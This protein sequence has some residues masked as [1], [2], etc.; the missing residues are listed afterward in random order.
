MNTFFGQDFLKAKFF[1]PAYLH[2]AGEAPPTQDG[3]SG[4]WRLF[5]MKMQEEALKKN[6]KETESKPVPAEVVA[7]K[8]KRVKRR[9]AK[10]Q[11]EELPAPEIKLAPFVLRPVVEQPNSYDALANLPPMPTATVFSLEVY[12][13]QVIISKQRKQKRRRAAAFLLLAA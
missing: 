10:V 3:K 8:P 2:G 1:K 7:I 4:Y 13:N 5:F 6:D 12:R 11:R 9:I